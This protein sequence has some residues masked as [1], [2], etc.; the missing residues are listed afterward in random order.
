MKD[1]LIQEV[2]TRKVITVSED[3]T[4]SAVEEK[5][6]KH[7]IRHLPVVD[8]RN[9]V[10]GIFTHH[11]FARCVAAR[12]T[13]EGYVYLKEELDQFILNRVMTPGPVTL[14]ET[15]TLQM[16]VEIM[17][18]DKYGCIPVVDEKN[19]LSGIISQIDVLRMLA[20]A[21]QQMGN[22]PPA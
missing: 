9:H 4:L 5:L 8:S 13:E 10:V 15:D 1:I 22:N 19:V 11:D 3:D 20:R 17:A 21:F 16:A 18:R 14:K 7:G 12:P 2:M 6:R